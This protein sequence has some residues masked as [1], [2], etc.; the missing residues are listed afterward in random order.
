VFGAM[1]DKDLRVMLA[2]LAPIVDRWYFCDLPTARAASAQALADALSAVATREVPV[3][4]HASPVEA[5]ADAAAAAEAADRIVVFGS[6]YTVGAVLQ[7]GVPRLGA[8]HLPA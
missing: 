4:R 7:Q 2:K 6:F 5:L 1:A 8:R 3:S